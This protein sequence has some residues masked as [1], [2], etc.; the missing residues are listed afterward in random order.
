M[1]EYLNKLFNTT[2]KRKWA[3]IALFVNEVINRSKSDN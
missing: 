2:T 1:E 3:I